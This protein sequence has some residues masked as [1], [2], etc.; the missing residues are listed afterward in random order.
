MA[1]Y[2]LKQNMRE[3]ENVVIYQSFVKLGEWEQPS[4][5]PGVDWI[6]LPSDVQQECSP[7]KT[8][9]V[10]GLNWWRSMESE[11]IYNL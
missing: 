1:V 4:S 10:G 2:I 3:E 8:V 9:G 7:P 5:A 11:V 6:G